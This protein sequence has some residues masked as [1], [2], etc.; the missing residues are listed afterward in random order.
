MQYKS[1]SVK[2]ELIFEGYIRLTNTELVIVRNG[3]NFNKITSKVIG[4]LPRDRRR[5][6]RDDDPYSAKIAI[7]LVPRVTGCMSGQRG[8]CR[9]F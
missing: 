4:E 2:Y 8:R 9:R 7:G 6:A 3:T 5:A 1:I